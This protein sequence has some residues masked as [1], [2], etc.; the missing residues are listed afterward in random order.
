MFF[1][2]FKFF[3]FLNIII[4]LFSCKTTDNLDKAS[5]NNSELKKFTISAE[6]IKVEN[7]YDSY[8]VDPFVDHLM[9]M[10]PSI[11]IQNWID[12]NI[13]ILGTE[14]QF[15]IIIKDA[16]ITQKEISVNK[17]SSLVTKQKEYLY[18]INIDLNFILLDDDNNKIAISEV[19]VSRST[20]SSIYISISERDKIL[21]NL[22]W[23]SMKDLSLESEKQLGQHMSNFI[24]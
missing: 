11:R 10:P 18:E 19:K 24:L 5:F 15:A 2:T 17:E 3:I 4:L 21:D 8:F 6:K 7:H 13:A 12:Q 22:V 14:N 20:T 1:K 16:S 9:S 23:D